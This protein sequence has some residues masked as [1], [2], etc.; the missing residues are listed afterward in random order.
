MELRQVQTAEGEMQISDNLKKLQELGQDLAREWQ[1]MKREV[2]RVA[3]EHATL[4]DTLARAREALLAE[5]MDTLYH[6]IRGDDQ[7]GAGAS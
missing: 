2:E 6:I 1:D 5:D 7:H 3:N 4:N